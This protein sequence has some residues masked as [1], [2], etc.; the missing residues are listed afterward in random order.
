M[1]LGVWMIKG[2]GRLL[3]LAIEGRRKGGGTWRRK[4]R[5][6]RGWGV[7]ALYWRGKG[8]KDRRGE[9]KYDVKARL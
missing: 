3:F 6:G 7:T 4:R 2:G 9:E 1:Q 8:G 5:D